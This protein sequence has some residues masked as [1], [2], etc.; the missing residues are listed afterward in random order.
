VVGARQKLEDGL[1][2][3]VY[4][5]KS[6]TDPTPICQDEPSYNLVKQRLCALA[7]ISSGPDSLS[8]SCDAV[9]GSLGV[10]YKPA[11]FGAIGSVT[12]SYPPCA[13]NVHPETDS[14]DTLTQ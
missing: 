13:P 14:C 6:L 9:S 12:I 10:W 5:P 3:F 7:D 11:L 1:R 2:G 4:G 8:S